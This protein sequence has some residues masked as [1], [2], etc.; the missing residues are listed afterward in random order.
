MDPL[1]G[2]LV[3]MALDPRVYF[4]PQ[5]SISRASFP[6]DFKVTLDMLRI[7]DLMV[8]GYLSNPPKSLS[9]TYYQL[10]NL[11]ALPLDAYVVVDSEDLDSVS[12]M[13]GVV[14]PSLEAE[15]SMNMHD[16]SI[17]WSEYWVS[18]LRGVNGFRVWGQRSTVGKISSNLSAQEFFAFVRS[19]QSVPESRINIASVDDTNLNSVSNEKGEIVSMIS[20]QD[21]DD[22]L[23]SLCTDIDIDR[24][25]A[26]V[27]IFN[28]SGVDGLGNMYRRFI[29]HLGADVIRVENAPGDWPQTK[30]Y[31]TDS[32]K[33]QYTVEKISS[34]W[35]GNVEIIDG[36]PDF[37]ATGDVIIVLGMD[38]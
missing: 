24:E 29:R 19:V 25:Q 5:I 9:M 28:G 11:L 16:R 23:D 7:R 12:K 10:E 32:E 2:E 33:F 35:P 13:A 22:V 3:S 15:Q 4:K 37:F 26:R 21:I 20:I 36:R 14:T 34:L 38:Y 17:M 1:Q 30:I 31:V 8:L 27:E 6:E 18:V